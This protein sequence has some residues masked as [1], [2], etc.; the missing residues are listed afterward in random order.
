MLKLTSQEPQSQEPQ[1]Q[2][3][4]LEQEENEQSCGH[5]EQCIKLSA[6]HFQL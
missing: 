4:Q 3:V 2:E 6:T 5:N 1:S